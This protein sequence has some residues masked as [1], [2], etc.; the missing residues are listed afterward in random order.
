VDLQSH[1]GL[2]RDTLCAADD[3][4]PQSP[5][6]RVRKRTARGEEYDEMPASKRAGRVPLCSRRNTCTRCVDIKVMRPQ[7]T[8]ASR[9]HLNEF[10]NNSK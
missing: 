8:T 7:E 3:E 6:K 2:N 10:A 5:G 9:L 4:V 1:Q